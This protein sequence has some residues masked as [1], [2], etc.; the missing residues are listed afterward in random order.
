[1]Q[2]SKMMRPALA[3]AAALTLGAAQAQAVPLT[4]V[5][6]SF[7]FPP[8][9]PTMLPALPIQLVPAFTGGL[10]AGWEVEGQTEVLG[11]FPPG[12]PIVAV[13]IVIFPNAAAD[14][15]IIGFSH[16][17]NL[18]GIQA[19]SVQ[20]TADAAMFQTLGEAFEVGESY[21]LT[22]AFG[23]SVLSPPQP[24]S[25]LMMEFFYDDNGQKVTIDSLLITEAELLS[26]VFQ[27][28][29]EMV[30]R[31]LTLDPVSAN[32]PWAGQP[33][34][35]RFQSVASV[36][37]QPGGFLNVDDVRVDTSAIG[38]AVP[39]PATMLGL[40]VGLA[41]MCIRRRRFA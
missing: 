11:E 35:I 21:S 12:N 34:G 30:D 16:I 27:D 37:T 3:L 20:V 23:R 28:H 36:T 2:T 32:D 40:G 29:A 22:A 4:V 18:D 5:N 17:T 26:T 33:I 15:P 41:A 31:V 39:E 7:E 14:D 1:M 13:P 8:V 6:H 25:G 19:A 38:A 9:A 24:G 10:S